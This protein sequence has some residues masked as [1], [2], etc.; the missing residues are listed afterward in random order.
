MLLSPSPALGTQIRA[1]RYT[2]VS[3]FDG[4]ATLAIGNTTTVTCGSTGYQ[5]CADVATAA[6]DKTP[7]CT[8]V[9]VAMVAGDNTT[10]AQTMYRLPKE[11]PTTP[12]SSL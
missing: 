6:C 8:A 11:A 9:A 2:C 7:G 1:R 5:G 3:Q 12:T 4:D 10:A